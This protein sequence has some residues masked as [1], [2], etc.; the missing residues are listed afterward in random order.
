M[1]FMSCV[2]TSRTGRITPDMP[3]TKCLMLIPAKI[4]N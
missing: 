4:T 3:N 2:L 1:D